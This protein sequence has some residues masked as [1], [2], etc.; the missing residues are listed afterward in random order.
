[1]FCEIFSLSSLKMLPLHWLVSTSG[2]GKIYFLQTIKGR[3]KI[4][5]KFKH[6]IKAIYKDYMAFL[7]VIAK[8]FDN[9]K[10]CSNKT[11]TYFR[12]V[13]SIHLCP[14]NVKACQSDLL[15]WRGL[16]KLVEKP[17]ASCKLITPACPNKLYP[18]ILSANILFFS[19]PPPPFFLYMTSFL[20]FRRLNV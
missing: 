12:H 15:A 20:F 19:P 1:M 2:L 5:T 13:L 6:N 3:L 7:K 18:P 16:S 11:W 9:P 14:A 17:A 8:K 4:R 10:I